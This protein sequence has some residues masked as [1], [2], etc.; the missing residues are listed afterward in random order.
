VTP[1]SH[2]SDPTPSML[3]RLQI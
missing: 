2:P 3:L 1:P